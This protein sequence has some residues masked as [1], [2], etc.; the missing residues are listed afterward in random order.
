[1][2]SAEQP[3]ICVSLFGVSLFGVSLLSVRYIERKL[4]VSC[5]WYE[6][7]RDIDVMAA[8]CAL[9]RAIERPARDVVTRDVVTRAVEDG[10]LWRL[11]PWVRVHH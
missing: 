9:V 4:L 2:H 1:M 5:V 6:F 10:S 3:P 8:V 11:A 7:N